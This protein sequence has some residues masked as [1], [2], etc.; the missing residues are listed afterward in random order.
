MCLPASGK[1]VRQLKITPAVNT[2]VDPDTPPKSFWLPGLTVDGF[3]P[4]HHPGNRFKKHAWLL[5]THPHSQ[6]LE[7]GLFLL[8]TV[9]TRDEERK[10]K[11]FGFSCSKRDFWTI[12]LLSIQCTYLVV[13]SRILPISTCDTNTTL[14]ECERDFFLQI[15]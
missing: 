13:K 7:T 2:Q 12:C 1:T 11:S 9:Y 4:V 15:F 10:C 8:V 6:T 5:N 3:E 14:S